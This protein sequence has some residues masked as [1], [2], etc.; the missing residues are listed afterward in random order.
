MTSP[1]HPG[2]SA[3]RGLVTALLVAGL[4]ALQGGAA[5]AT[6]ARIR[7]FPGN[8]AYWEY[9][10]QPVVLLGGSIEDNLFQIGELD[11]HLDQLK[12]SGGN[13]VRNTMSSRDE[14]NVWPFARTADGKYDLTRL[15]DAYWQRFER[16]L[17]LA[18]ERG[19]VVQIEVWDRFDFAREPWKANPYNPANNVSYTSEKSGLQPDYPNH[20][21]RNENPFFRSVPALEHNRTLLPFQHAQVDRL[22]AISLAYGNV[23]Y[24]M[25]N[26]TNG[27]PA[28]GAY[29]AKYIRHA[30]R[31][32]GVEVHTTE[33]WDP[34]DLGDPMHGYTFD[35]PDLY[36]F[37]D[38]SQNNHQKGQTH[39]DNMQR[40]R[41]R[42]AQKPRPM[43]NVK[44][45]G[46]DTG[47]YGTDQDGTERFWRNVIGGMASA[48]FHRPA[49]G[50]GLTPRSQ[51]HI[52]S[53]RMLADRFPFVRAT[54]DAASRRLLDR[55]P[56]EAY[57][58]TAGRQHAIYF[59]NGGAVRLDPGGRQAR[60]SI[61]WL[62]VV[63]SRWSDA[64]T[65]SGDGAVAL[66]PPAAGQWVALVEPVE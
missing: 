5:R 22:L 63:Q 65:P 66:A 64:V 25:D 50:L 44:I 59:P 8:P 30:A 28:W 1:R 13:Y 40:Q 27:D 26:E 51:S 57:L 39:W 47:P 52:R 19:I 18:R 24:C 31:T 10:G 21:G 6:D 14:G 7:P 29:W 43:N 9:G 35:H 37:V 15:D 48:R 23:L 54:P 45:Y 12:A 60:F 56:N 32:R 58:T 11:R 46:A 17:Q 3:T 62:D 34:W 53:A 16:L 2:S 42:L 61:R 4:A 55:E 33:M 41:S 36:T 49:S 20:P 38:V